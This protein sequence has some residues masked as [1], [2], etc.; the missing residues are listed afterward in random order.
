MITK[1]LNSKKMFTTDIHI[2][3]TAL[4]LG[5]PM[6]RECHRGR[7][8]EL[9]VPWVLAQN[10][11]RGRSAMFDWPR[12]V[13]AGPDPR[14]AGRESDQL[15]S[16]TPANSNQKHSPRQGLCEAQCVEVLWGNSISL[17]RR[18]RPRELK[19]MPGQQEV[20]PHCLASESVL[21]TS[22]R[23]RLPGL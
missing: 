2:K 7:K 13:Q 18:L 11:H 19:N 9:P 10:R 22:T 5:V 4:R 23:R 3:A 6:Q 1:N 12:Q 21:S 8:G 20:T 17:R 15:E 16:T 14:E